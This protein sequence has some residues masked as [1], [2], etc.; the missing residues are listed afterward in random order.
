LKKPLP[1]GVENFEKLITNN[2]YYADK[3]MFIKELLPKKG[4]VNLFTRP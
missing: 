4:D 2:Y 1:I 3:T